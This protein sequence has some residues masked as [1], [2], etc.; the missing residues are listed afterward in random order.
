MRGYLIAPF[1]AIVVFLLFVDTIVLF[2][3]NIGNVFFLQTIYVSDEKVAF[4]KAQQTI[5]QLELFNNKKSN[6]RLLRMYELQWKSASALGE[7]EIALNVYNNGHTLDGNFTNITG[8]S[9]KLGRMEAEDFSGVLPDTISAPRW[10]DDRL[11]ALL[12]STPAITQFV[13]LPTE[14]LYQITVVSR[15]NVPPPIDIAVIWDEWQAGL[16]SYGQGNGNWTSQTVDIVSPAGQHEL[17]LSFQNDFRD[18][19][20]GIDRNAMIDYIEIDLLD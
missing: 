17:Q 18:S 2:H 8:C 19:V 15:E 3:W 6:A 20:S 14:G 4:I 11:V 10:I 12:F 1:L 5:E 16:L 13:C 7:K 9:P